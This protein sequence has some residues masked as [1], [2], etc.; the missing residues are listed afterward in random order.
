LDEIIIINKLKGSDYN[1]K[2]HE[3]IWFCPSYRPC[4]TS[5]VTYH[6]ECKNLFLII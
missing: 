4:G 6:R 3:I 1:E 5:M 2:V